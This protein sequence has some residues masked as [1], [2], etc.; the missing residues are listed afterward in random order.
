MN[1]ESSSLIGRAFFMSVGLNIQCYM[2]LAVK[3]KSP[4]MSEATEAVQLPSRACPGELSALPR[5]RF[6]PPFSGYSV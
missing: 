6:F 5:G 2:R 4:S 3:K 1:L